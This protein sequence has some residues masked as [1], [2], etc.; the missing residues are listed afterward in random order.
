MD[1]GRRRAVW[2]RLTIVAFLLALTGTALLA[3]CGGE[4]SGDDEG[5]TVRFQKPTD[6]GPDPFAKKTDVR[7]AKRVKVGSGPFGGTG[8]DL[9][10]RRG[11]ERRRG[12]ALHPHP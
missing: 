5:Q 9:V 7:R 12:G 11:A 1:A 2:P 4:D 8:S 6:P 3:G 10:A